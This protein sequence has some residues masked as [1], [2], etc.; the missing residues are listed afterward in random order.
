[1]FD[2]VEI[3]TT[4]A[5]VN[6]NTHNIRQLFGIIKNTGGDNTITYIITSKAAVDGTLSNV[7]KEITDIL[8]G[9]Q[10]TFEFI[11]NPRTSY[12]ITL[13]EKVDDNPS[14]FTVEYCTLR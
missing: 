6:I 4:D 9:A 3:G 5:V 12:T 10:A 2:D 13:A 11:D 8:P 14:T 7:E 1:M